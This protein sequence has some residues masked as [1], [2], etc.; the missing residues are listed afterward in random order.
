[1]VSTRTVTG[2]SPLTVRVVE[3]AHDLSLT[4]SA[5]LPN[6]SILPAGWANLDVAVR[7]Q[8]FVYELMDGGSWVDRVFFHGWPLCEPI[9][10]YPL[11]ILPYL[12]AA[13]SR[14]SIVLF[15][16][17][18]LL[19]LFPLLRFLERSLHRSSSDLRRR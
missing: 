14:L 3:K 5:G 17:H 12:Y 8:L 7:F 4:P 15:H 2:R 1:M 19:D 13:F 10:Y 16:L 6:G 9:N 11:L 18:L